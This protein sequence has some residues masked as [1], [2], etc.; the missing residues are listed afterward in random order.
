[1]G[2]KI[3]PRSLRI[4]LGKICHEL[5]KEHLRRRPECKIHM[6]RSF[7]LRMEEITDM[8][9]P[10]QDEKPRKYHQEHGKEG[11]RYHDMLRD[12]VIP[13]HRQRGCLQDTTFRQ[14]G[15]PPHIDRCVKDSL[16]QHFTDAQA[17]SR[18]ISA[19]S[20]RFISQRIPFIEIRRLRHV[21]HQFGIISVPMVQR[22]ILWRRVSIP[23]V[24]S[25]SLN[26]DPKVRCQSPI[27][28]ALA[29]LYRAT[30]I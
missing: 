5:R 30:L 7:C 16:K 17:I 3:T 9:C 26:R 4:H 25:S 12:F 29:L 2:I 23:G 10:L 28:L 24:S 8:Q 1:M 15:A 27:A 22:T 21:L 19:V 18:P 6:P 14:D 11:K 13:E 20:E